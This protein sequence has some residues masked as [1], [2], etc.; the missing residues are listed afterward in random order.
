MGE[1]ATIEGGTRNIRA[2]EAYLAGNAAYIGMKPDPIEAVRH[3]ERAVELDPNYAIAWAQLAEACHVSFMD[4]GHIEALRL[5]ERRDQAISKA[6]SLAPESARVLTVLAQL[7]IW[8][9][10]YREARILLDRLHLRYDGRE[11][12][13]SFAW[14]DLSLKMGRYWDSLRAIESIRRRDPLNPLIPNSLGQ[15]YLM[16]DRADDALAERERAFQS[17]NRTPYLA[18]TT[19]PIALATGRRD[20]IEKW[21]K[22]TH[23]TL[24]EENLFPQTLP[25][26]L[27]DNLDDREALLEGM[28][29][30]QS[31]WVENDFQVI[32]WAAYLG[33][34]EMALRSL[35][36]T[37][38]P[39]IFW[40]PLLKRIRKTE[41][42]KQILIDEGFVDY[43]R[44][45]G[46]GDFCKPT[47]GDDFECK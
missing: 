18:G 36:R 41:E 34:D 37:P 40:N 42:F 45:F 7:H 28:A 24:K 44:E 43:W 4:Y 11:I 21:L 46:W 38:D 27:L 31:A 13:Y 20:E 33:D 15:F 12:P 3:Y 19:V 14:L 2:Y 35:Q 22:R 23:D 16:T 1:I 10:D 5:P 47:V 39:W 32:H 29:R 8:Q 25:E 6:L 17:G 30:L 26:A 9:Y